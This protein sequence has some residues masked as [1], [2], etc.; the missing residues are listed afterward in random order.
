M[1]GVGFA[2][3]TKSAVLLGAM[4]V[5]SSDAF[6]KTCSQDSPATQ[7]VQRSFKLSVVDFQ[8]TPKANVKVVLGSI[9]RYD[10]M[11]AV[12]T[13]VTD[14]SGV[15]NFAKLPPGNFSFQFTDA[16]GE[17]QRVPVKVGASGGDAAFEYAWPNVNWL[18][19]R[20]ASGILR[21]GTNPLRHYQVTLL[22]YPDANP[23]GT[24]D[25]DMQGRFDLPALKPGRYW[26]ELSQAD[27]ESGQPTRFGRIP[28]IV[29]LDNRYAAVDT[30]FVTENTCGLQYDQFCTRQPAKLEG[31]CIKTVDSN[32][33]GIPKAS[34][35][36]K[37]Q[38]GSLDA[39]RFTADDNGTLRVPNL[40][41]GDYQ[42]EV[43]ANGFTP[44]RQTVTIVPGL[45][46]CSTAVVVPMNAFGSG[47]AP[48]TQGK[49]N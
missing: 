30:I 33:A 24:S 35:S 2:G 39:S 15:L 41:A 44:V 27:T 20:S 6:S 22:G 47:C 43:L 49:G 34:L 45:A 17:R 23:M 11:H 9:D 40:S 4:L 26:V 16:M 48:A 37:A 13:G 1:A 42:L 38:H 7:I 21:N 31:W 5:L 32:G 18:P 36:L 28:I 29:T 12:S 25:T 19:L 8:S 10:V 14:K 3:R 46:S